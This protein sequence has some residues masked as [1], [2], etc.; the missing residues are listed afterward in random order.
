MPRKQTAA[1]EKSP[2]HKESA[3][4]RKSSDRET[5][6]TTLSPESTRV[7]EAVIDRA[8]QVIGDEERAM[9]WMGTPVPALDY[10]TP[11]SRLHDSQGQADVL[12]VLTQLE[13]G[14]L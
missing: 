3:P 1:P 13:H 11:I 6:Q 5:R 7:Y 10:A 4:L 14:V 2:V 12:R 8:I 9:R